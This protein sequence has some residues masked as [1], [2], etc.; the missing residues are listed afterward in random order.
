MELKTGKVIP[1]GGE[2]Q[3]AVLQ[4]LCTQFSMLIDEVGFYVSTISANEQ[5]LDSKITELAEKVA[6]LENQEVVS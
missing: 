3:E 4:R 2:S 1:R 6:A 5:K